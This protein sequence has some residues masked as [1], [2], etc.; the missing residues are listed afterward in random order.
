M[1]LPEPEADL[2]K[3][4]PAPAASELDQLRAEIWERLAHYTGRTDNPQDLELAPQIGALLFEARK[5]VHAQAGPKPTA[6][7]R[8]PAW[9]RK[10][11]K[12]WE[13]WTVTL[14]H[15]PGGRVRLMGPQRADFFLQQRGFSG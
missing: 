7:S 9:E 13:K 2:T 4:Q 1:V 11:D 8:I 6:K 15:L 10:R 14:Q 3:P 12:L 5:I